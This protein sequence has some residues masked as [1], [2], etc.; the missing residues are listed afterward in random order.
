MTRG[1][2]IQLHTGKYTMG[3]LEVQLYTE[4]FGKANW[5]YKYIVENT[6]GQFRVGILE[7]KYILENTKIIEGNV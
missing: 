2:E 1:L 6:G 3:S 4:K 7:Y 5:I